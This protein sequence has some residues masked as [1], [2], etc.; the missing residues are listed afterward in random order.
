VKSERTIQFGRW[1][2][3]GWILFSLLVVIPVGFYSKFYT[4]P[5]AHWVNNSLGG[6]FYEIFWCLLI[7]G[8]FPH[9]SPKWIAG[10]VC[11]ATCGLEFLQLWHP[12]YL[13]AVRRTFIGQ[14]ILGTTFSLLDFPY[15]IAGSGAGYFLLR[16]IGKVR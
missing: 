14:T 1:S 16:I 15:Y 4:G 6:L 13:E 8:L 10:S 9:L 5:A 11:M 3:R 7:A 2:Q 12:P